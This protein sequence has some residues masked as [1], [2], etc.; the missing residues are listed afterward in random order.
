MGKG[1]GERLKQTLR[2]ILPAFSLSHQ[3]TSSK[4]RVA[5]DSQANALRQH[6]RQVKAGL[7]N[8]R[9]RP[10]KWSQSPVPPRAGCAYET[11]LDTGPTA[12][13]AFLTGSA[14]SH[15]REMV[16]TGSRTRGQSCPRSATEMAIERF[17]EKCKRE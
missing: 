3:P 1:A 12:L 5:T 2:S 16:L 11:R 8:H 14:D 17:G 4:W 10:M 13:A 6:F 9:L 7:H 15:V